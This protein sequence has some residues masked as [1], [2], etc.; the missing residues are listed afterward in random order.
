MIPHSTELTCIH[1]C[2]LRAI[3]LD[4]CLV[5]GDGESSCC[6]CTTHRDRPRLLHGTV[7]ALV[8]SGI[9]CSLR[10]ARRF[11]FF[12]SAIMLHLLLALL[13]LFLCPLSSWSFSVIVYNDSACTVPFTN[14]SISLS[15]PELTATND[16]TVCLTNFSNTRVTLDY[17]C[18]VATGSPT[19]VAVLSLAYYG[20]GG[21]CVGFGPTMDWNLLGTH[22]VQGN[23]SSMS[24]YNGSG[25]GRIRTVYGVSSCYAA[26]N[27]NAAHTMTGQTRA[28]LVMMVVILFAA[29]WL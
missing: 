22:T 6:A 8:H 12:L 21:D 13:A 2:P 11:C 7:E 14:P 3:D 18:W 20:S 5:L 28:A 19:G 4:A 27:S 16:S 29:I 15:Y 23:C 17:M 1:L 10:V 24:L 9:T 25:L 26:G